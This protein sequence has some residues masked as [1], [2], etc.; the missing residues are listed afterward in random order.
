[1]RDYTNLDWPETPFGADQRPFG[2]R[3]D[4][5][6]AFAFDWATPRA[7]WPR[8]VAT[9]YLRIRRHGNAQKV[10]A[11]TLPVGLRATVVEDPADA[12][13]LMAVADRALTRARATPRS[14]PVT[15][16]TTTCAA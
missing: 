14:W 13:D 4:M 15:T 9:V 10:N 11:Q 3:R 7:R 6:A 8:A 2:H 5:L 12:P 16:S 1:M